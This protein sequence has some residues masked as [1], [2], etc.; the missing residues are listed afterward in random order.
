MKCG[1]L[2]EAMSMIKVAKSHNLAVI[3]GCYSNSTLANVALAHLGP[4]VD[5]VDLDSHFNIINDPFV[6]GLYREG[7]FMA[8]D[9]PG[10]GVRQK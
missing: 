4:L 3:F 6:G 2:R 5:V 9:E 8:T 7:C 10:L 1:G